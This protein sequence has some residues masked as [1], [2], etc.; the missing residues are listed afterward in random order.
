[1]TNTVAL[2]ITPPPPRF[3]NVTVS[4]GK[5][6]MSATGPP[7]ASFHL[8]TSTNPALPASNW[9]RLATHQFDAA[10]NGLLTNLIPVDVAQTFY[11]LQLP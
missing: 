8:L 2:L 5:V 9:T 3:L 6:V 11:R 10:G 7:F 1:M 4:A